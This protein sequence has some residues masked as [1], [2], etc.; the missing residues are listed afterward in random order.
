MGLTGDDF[1]IRPILITM[2]DQ[3]HG[4][5]LWDSDSLLLRH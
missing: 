1:L 5:V 4:F 2:Y 3:A